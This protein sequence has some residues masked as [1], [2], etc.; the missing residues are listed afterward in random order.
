MNWEQKLVFRWD[1]RIYAVMSL[2][3]CEI[4][5]HI[6]IKSI[7]SNLRSVG[8]IKQ[9][10][11]SNNS[12]TRTFSF[13][14]NGNEQKIGKNHDFWFYTSCEIKKKSKTKKLGNRRE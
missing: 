9:S 4:G 6:L 7:V 11:E 3:S 5:N 2:F 13:L 12:F 14:K 8:Q 1:H 10:L